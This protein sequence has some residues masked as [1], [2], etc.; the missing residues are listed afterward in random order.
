MLIYLL[1]ADRDIEIVADRGIDARVG[2][3]EWEAICRAMEAELRAGRYE[4]G[5]L[6]GVHA[7]SELLARHFPPASATPTSSRTG[8]SCCED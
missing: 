8:P 5:A 6:E 3:A 7:V 2:E 1:L 4:A